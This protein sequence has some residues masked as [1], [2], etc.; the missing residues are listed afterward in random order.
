MLAKLVKKRA[1]A[2]SNIEGLGYQKVEIGIAHAQVAL[3]V[4]VVVGVAF[5]GGVTGGVEIEA[6]ALF[7]QGLPVDAGF[8]VR[9]QFGED[10][11]VFFEDAIDVANHPVGFAVALVVVGI[12]ATVRTKTFVGPAQDGFAAIEAFT[13]GVHRRNCGLKIGKN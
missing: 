1:A 10:L 8:F 9:V 7:E 12:A 13:F 11:P 5:A 2:G 3:V 6:E 4:N